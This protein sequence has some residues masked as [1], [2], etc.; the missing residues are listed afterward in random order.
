MR[1]HTDNIGEQVATRECE[2]LDDE[3]EVVIGVLNAWDR[4]V[5]DLCVYRQWYSQRFADWNS[6]LVDDAG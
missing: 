2:V 1:L 3:V 4:N 5:S 6:N